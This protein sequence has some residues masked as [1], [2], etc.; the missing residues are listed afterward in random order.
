MKSVDQHLAD[1]LAGIEPL[2]PIDQPPAAAGSPKLTKVCW[3]RWLGRTQNSTA[4][5]VP[6]TC[7]VIVPPASKR[8]AVLAGALNGGA[9]PSAMPPDIAPVAAP[10]LESAAVFPDVSSRCQYAS[11]ASAITAPR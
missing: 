9:A 8:I 4:F 5:A 6:G 11:G 2:S 7:A 10:P 1:C 3:T